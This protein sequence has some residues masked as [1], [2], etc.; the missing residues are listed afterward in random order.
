MPLDK[1]EG[2]V[3]EKLSLAM[4]EHHDVGQRVEDE[5]SGKKHLDLNH[6]SVDRGSLLPCRS[7]NHRFGL[8][9][10]P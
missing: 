7:T 9:L 10:R 1:R 4:R 2:P 5:D 6:P 3:K 8:T